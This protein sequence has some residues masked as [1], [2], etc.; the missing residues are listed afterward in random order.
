MGPLISDC[1]SHLAGF[2]TVGV[3][4]HLLGGQLAARVSIIAE[5][6]LPERPSS[7]ELPLS[8]VVWCPWSCRNTTSLNQKLLGNNFFFFLTKSPEAAGAAVIFRL[9]KHKHSS[10]HPNPQQSPPVS[11]TI[12]LLKPDVRIHRRL[13]K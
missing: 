2:L 3:K 10:V 5:V 9:S 1:A 7:Q 8:P 12:T 4:G 13:V 6:H 11:H